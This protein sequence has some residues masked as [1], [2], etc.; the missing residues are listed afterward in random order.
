MTLLDVLKNI[1]SLNWKD[2]LYLP[3]DKSLWGLGSEAII[4]NP[5]GFDVYD[6]DGNPVELSDVGYQYVLLC[7]DLH[8][9]FSNIKEQGQI[10]DEQ[11]ACDAFIFY[12]ENDAY[13]SF[14]VKAKC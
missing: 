3:K 2:A 6:D 9:I 13:M 8:S 11:L 14:P 4:A 1:G 12:L 10:P 7:D 5:D